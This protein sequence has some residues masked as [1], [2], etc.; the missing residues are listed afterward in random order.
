MIVKNEEA[1]LAHCLGSVK[2]LVEEIIIIDTGS[3]DSTI[4]IAKGFGAQIHSFNWCDDFAAARNESL[5][6]CRGDWV[7]VMDA[8]E[9][10]DP[11]DY[12]K[13]INACTHPT[14]DAYNLVSRNYTTTAISTSQDSGAVPN[15]SYYSEGKDLPFYA[16]NPCLRLAKNFDGL[17]YTGR[18]HESL[19]QSLLANGKAIA[20]LDAVIHHYGK[21]FNDRE[22]RKV[23]YYFLLAA[24]ESEKKP[25]DK[26]ALFNLLQQ[27]L[28]AKQWKVALE[29]AEASIR[30]HSAVEALVLYG[31]GLALQEL[32][33]HEEAIKYFD[34]LLSSVPTHSLAMLR[35]GF[36]YG[37]MGNINDG[38]KLMGE[39]IEL[40]P[41]YIPGHG[42]LAE[43]ELRAG[44]FGT[45]RNIALGAIK[46]APT[47]PM[48][49]DLLVKIELSRQGIQQAAQD[50]M[51][52]IERCPKGGNGMW[53][54]VAA[55][56]F[57][58]SGERDKARSILEKG[59]DA[60]PGDAEL[61]RI[62]GMCG[63]SS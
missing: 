13:I 23:Q 20:P 60:F 43:L 37:A 5:K 12:E 45:A 21:L 3:T 6:Y 47:E 14:A 1:R 31:G 62:K 25:S 54:R 10:I 44:N 11:L 27:A 56:F 50:A 32:G 49:Y 38:R 22:E 36:S 40:A 42:Y 2:P 59:L 19:G 53:H 7:F 29:A 61:G 24:K 55:L 58:Q 39:A 26:W 33:R 16:D 17:S 15:T 28:A 4:D 57:L 9:A 34:L 18:I 51:L 8:D 41:N 48:L 63:H 35:K 30:Q 46:L 52:G